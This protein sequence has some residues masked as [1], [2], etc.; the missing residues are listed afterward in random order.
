[1]STRWY[2]HLN[3][4][5]NR[6][7]Q[8]TLLCKYDEYEPM[9]TLKSI[10]LLILTLLGLVGCPGNS[11]KTAGIGA[12]SPPP[13]SLNC[14]SGFVEINKL[15][16]YNSESYYLKTIY[17]ASQSISANYSDAETFAPLFN[18]STETLDKGD[19]VFLTASI[20][21][22]NEKAESVIAALDIIPSNQP[23]SILTVS[24]SSF[25]G[26][27]TYL[28]LNAIAKYVAQSAM[29][30]SFQARLGF[31]SPAVLGNQFSFESGELKALV[32]RKS[33]LL[34]AAKAG[35]KG[36]NKTNFLGYANT[37]YRPSEEIVGDGVRTNQESAIFSVNLYENI[38]LDLEDQLF[39][40][41]GATLFV[42]DP[43]LC[44]GASFKYYLKRDA[45][46]VSPEMIASV[47]PG[48]NHLP[49][50]LFATTKISMIFPK[51][52][53]VV[54]GIN[55]PDGCAITLKGDNDK[56]EGP[57]GLRVEVYKRALKLFSH[58]DAS[59]KNEALGLSVFIFDYRLDELIDAKKDERPEV[60]PEPR[61]VAGCIAK[62][63]GYKDIV[64]LDSQFSVQAFTMPNALGFPHAPD[65]IEIIA[66]GQNSRQKNVSTYHLDTTLFGAYYIGN[67]GFADIF[68]ASAAAP[69][70]VLEEKFTASLYAINNNENDV[71]VNINQVFCR[72]FSTVGF[73]APE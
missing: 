14:G 59:R 18:L 27:N 32:F 62:S 72:Q 47:G 12:S 43:Q 46:I 3:V 29:E 58:L 8:L 67:L 56:N 2:H 51:I 24:K 4:H 70:E 1:M 31:K 10:I 66:L 21:L 48:Q 15:C 39:L 40:S 52:S 41:G 50:F 49:I 73:S 33:N 23:D 11:K 30:G 60:T 22:K 9:L 16:L 19:V 54:Q 63:M 71:S 38:L 69:G 36:G 45:E 17:T 13:S 68:G 44:I 5:V 6:E 34:Q 37:Y 7:N 42:E 35:E 26:K 61:E 28:N 25:K 64:I 55:I 65:S 20:S 53:F 57:A